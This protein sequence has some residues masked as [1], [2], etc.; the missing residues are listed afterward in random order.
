M[1]KDYFFFSNN[2]AAL[3]I[4]TYYLGIH[5]SL[6]TRL[7]Q[8]HILGVVSFIVNNNSPEQNFVEKKKKI[9]PKATA[10]SILNTVKCTPFQAVA[11][12][13]E[14][15]P[16]IKEKLFSFF[17]TPKGITGRTDIKSSKVKASEYCVCK[18][19]Q[20]K[21]GLRDVGMVMKKTLL[22]F[23]EVCSRA[24]NSYVCVIKKFLVTPYSLN[25]IRKRSKK[26]S[27]KGF[28]E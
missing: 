2:S 7:R 3:E 27:F 11:G 18:V 12:Y 13:F 10:H 28:R 16:K 24:R 25:T 8:L 15:H 23:R 20:E 6:T 4:R 9:L 14:F 22:L 26:S 17:F 19:A 1:K 5:S 21:Y